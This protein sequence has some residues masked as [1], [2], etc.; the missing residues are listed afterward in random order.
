M[1]CSLL[2]L[3]DNNN[4]KKKKKEKKTSTSRFGSQP[5]RSFH[6]FSQDSIVSFCFFFVCCFSTSPRHPAHISTAVH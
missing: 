2:S 5:L 4:T 6:K 1:N 3:H